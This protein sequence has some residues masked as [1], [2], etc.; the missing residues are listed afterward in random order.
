[1]TAFNPPELWDTSDI[2]AY[3][4]VSRKTVQNGVVNQPGFPRAIGGLR[5]N[6]LWIAE[7]VLHYLL[8]NRRA[9]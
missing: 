7:E 3:L 6:R 2:A 1:M 9:A 5:R 4:K 8:K